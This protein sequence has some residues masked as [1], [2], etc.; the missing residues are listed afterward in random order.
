M[1]YKMFTYKYIS[2]ASNMSPNI[3]GLSEVANGFG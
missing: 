3:S 1:R 2:A